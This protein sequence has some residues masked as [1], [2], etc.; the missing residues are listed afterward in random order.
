MYQAPPLRDI[1]QPLSAESGQARLDRVRLRTSS[2][3]VAAKPVDDAAA[4]VL[5]EHVHRPDREVLDQLVQIFAPT[6]ALL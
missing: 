5:A 3:C 2:G 4:D 6:A 1:R